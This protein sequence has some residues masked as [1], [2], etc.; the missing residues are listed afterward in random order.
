MDIIKKVK[1]QEEQIE[2]LR[3]EIASLK[4]RF[5]RLE[6]TQPRH[7]VAHNWHLLGL[8]G[9]FLGSLALLTTII[10]WWLDA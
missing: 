6:M 2:D 5:I 9:L 3:G 7:T 1:V 8:I 4:D 10:H